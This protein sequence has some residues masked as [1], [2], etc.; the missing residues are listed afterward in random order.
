MEGH[1]SRLFVYDM[2]RREQREV[3]LPKE[4]EIGNLF[5]ITNDR[6]FFTGQIY[7]WPGRSPR[8]YEYHLEKGSLRELPY[9]DGAPAST[10]GSDAS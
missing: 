9:M 4:M 7:E 6:L 10:V 8:F 5:F 3:E 1:A 2:A